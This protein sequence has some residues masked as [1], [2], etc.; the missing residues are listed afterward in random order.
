MTTN[1]IVETSKI[2]PSLTVINKIMLVVLISQINEEKYI[3]KQLL[4][5]IE[6][7]LLLFNT[8]SSA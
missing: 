3:S 7:S 2:S 6:N 4:N 5:Y 1:N 8:L